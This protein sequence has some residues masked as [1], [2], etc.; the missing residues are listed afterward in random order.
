MKIQYCS[1]IHLE[2]PENK[3]FLSEN[4]LPVIGDILILAGDIVPF[5][6]MD[7]HQDFFKTISDNFKYTYWI[8]GNHE[9]YRSD[10]M[11]KYGPLNEK[12]RSNVHLVNNTSI[13]HENVTFIFSTL[14]SKIRPAYQW[15]I[16]RGMSDFHVIKY[17]GYRFSADKF[18]QLH[19]ESLNF[20]EEELNNKKTK[21]TIVTTHHV[22]TLFN[23]PEKYKGDVLN[24]AFAVELFDMIETKGPDYWIYGHTHNNTT[25]FEIGKTKLLTNQLGYLMH[26]EHKNFIM[27]KNIVIN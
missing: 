20:I 16:E 23:Y 3:K 5:A 9:Y 25:D 27:D 12:I 7:K 21:K 8:P 24:D 22:P 19:D 11:D 1:D 17:N 6:V 2:F 13:I 4:P 18:N 10:I 15:Q 14:W 26:N